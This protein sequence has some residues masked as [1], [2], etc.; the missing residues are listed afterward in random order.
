MGE[1]EKHFDQVTKI[2]VTNE[3]QIDTLSLQM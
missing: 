2:N 3:E 1:T